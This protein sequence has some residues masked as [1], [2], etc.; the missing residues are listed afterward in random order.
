MKDNSNIT[1]IQDDVEI[2]LRLRNKTINAGKRKKRQ[3][4]KAQSNIHQKH[5]TFDETKIWEARRI[6]KEHNMACNEGNHKEV[7]K[8]LVQK[9]EQ[10][11]KNDKTNIEQRNSKTETIEINKRDTVDQSHDKSL[12]HLNDDKSLLQHKHPHD[13]RINS[14]LLGSI[15]KKNFPQPEGK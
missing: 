7:C 6:I 9:L 4:V 1:L 14:C 8:D 11:T 10:L 5:V 15:L 2:Y 13:K 3:A 12:E